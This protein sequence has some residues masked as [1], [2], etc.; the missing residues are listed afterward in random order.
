MN[1]INNLEKCKPYQ[2]ATHRRRIMIEDIAT[3]E[4]LAEYIE[5][6]KEIKSKRGWCKMYKKDMQQV[7]MDLSNKP[8][9]MKI[10]LYLWDYMKKDGTIA[11]PK[12]KDIANALGSTKESVS[13]AFKTLKDF[14][15]IAKINNEWRY[16][17][18]LF[19]VT[20]QK[21]EDLREAQRIWESEIGC[22]MFNVKTKK[23]VSKYSKKAEE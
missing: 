11:M 18:F 1:Y 8:L 22:Y 19:G 15:I 17:P 5:P 12:Q 6:T 16:N 23:L 2:K 14:E 10:W 20:N 3:D 7:L 4:I 21:D 9:A 13:R